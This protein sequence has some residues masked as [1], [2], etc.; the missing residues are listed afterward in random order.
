M[1]L[2]DDDDEFRLRAAEEPFA[3][4]PNGAGEA[5]ALPTH[6]RMVRSMFTARAST[7]SRTFMS[8]FRESS[9]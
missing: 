8:K 1:Q 6:R 2:P 7:I 5:S 9:W 3:E 4:A